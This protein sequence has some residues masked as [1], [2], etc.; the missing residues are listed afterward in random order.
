MWIKRLWSILRE[1]SRTDQKFPRTY[2]EIGQLSRFEHRIH[3]SWKEE[4]LNNWR[5]VIRLLLLVFRNCISLLA[6]RIWIF[7]SQL[8]LFFSCLIFRIPNLKRYNKIKRLKLLSKCRYVSAKQ[9]WITSKS[10]ALLNVFTVLVLQKQCCLLHW[11]YK[12]NVI[13]YASFTETIL[14]IALLLQKQCYCASFTETMLFIVLVLQKQCL[15]RWFYRN[16]IVYC[17]GCK[18]PLLFIALVLQ[19]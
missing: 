2:E 15:L 7:L 18:R 6:R 3:L 10:I 12:N 16:N 13:Y 5:Q 11:L 8:F 14:F 4:L 17:A 19:K 1:F 9:H